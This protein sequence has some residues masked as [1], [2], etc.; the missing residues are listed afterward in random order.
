MEITVVSM[1]DH[2]QKLHITGIEIDRD[3]LL[4]RQHKHLSQLYEVILTKTTI[5]LQRPFPGFLGLYR[6]RIRP[7]N[8]FKKTH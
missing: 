6:A 7:M 3:R 1:T 2:C 8:H 4:A 5:K